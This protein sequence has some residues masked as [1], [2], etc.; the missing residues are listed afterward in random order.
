MF[1]EPILGLPNYIPHEA[2]PAI[3]GHK[4]VS[5]HF[6]TK[7]RRLQEVFLAQVFVISQAR[8]VVIEPML[9]LLDCIPRGPP[10]DARSNRFTKAASNRF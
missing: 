7:V 2:L 1:I 5:L 3:L 10:R 8:I 6:C 9:G 4:L